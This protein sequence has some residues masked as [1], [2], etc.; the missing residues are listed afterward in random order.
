MIEKDKKSKKILSGIIGL[1]LG[2]SITGVVAYSVYANTVTYDNTQSGLQSTEVQRAID[3]LYTKANN[4]VPIDPDTFKT[5]TAKTVYASKLGV[6][7]R[8]NNKLNCFKI[9]N[10][11][12]E[13]DH[14]QQ[15]FSDGSCIVDSVSSYDYVYCEASDFRCYA[16]SDGTVFC[17]D[18][19][20]NSRCY[21]DSYGTVSCY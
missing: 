5:N 1:I 10:W 3:E 16:Y 19:S 15:V 18:T 7:F 20:D 6:C 9:K 12:I 13:K 2:I 14:L 11:D 8:R 4:M 17:Y 21:V